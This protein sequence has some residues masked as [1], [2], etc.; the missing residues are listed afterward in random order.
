V[1]TNHQNEYQ[2]INKY[3]LSE[4]LPYFPSSVRFIQSVA[5]IEKKT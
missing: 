1:L 2:D 3:E 4:Y 5:R